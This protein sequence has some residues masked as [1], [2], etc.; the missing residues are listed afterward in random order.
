M[1]QL[2]CLLRLLLCFLCR[3]PAHHVRRAGS[4]RWQ[5]LVHGSDVVCRHLLHHW[6]R[7]LLLLLLRGVGGLVLQL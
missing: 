1:R 6:G 5:L 4:N 2:L 3:C 7:S